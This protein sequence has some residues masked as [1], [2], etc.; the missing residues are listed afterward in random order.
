[1]DRGPTLKQIAEK[2]PGM[3]RKMNDLDCFRIGDHSSGKLNPCYVL[4]AP[5]HGRFVDVNDDPWV[6]VRLANQIDPTIPV[7]L[8]DRHGT[9]QVGI[10]IG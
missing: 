7:L 9:R 6:L 2:Y 10:H 8:T 5:P 4:V 3:F 1:M